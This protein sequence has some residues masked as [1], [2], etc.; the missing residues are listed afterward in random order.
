MF[1]LTVEDDQVLIVDEKHYK[2][3]P[4]ENISPE[5]MMGYRRRSQLLV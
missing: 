4:T 5:E 2:L 1:E 3:V